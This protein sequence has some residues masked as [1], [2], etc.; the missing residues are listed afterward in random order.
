MFKQISEYFEPFFSKFQCDFWNG[1]SLQQCFLSMLE[2]WKLAVDNQK[3]FWALLWDLSKAFDCLSH[4]LFIAKL[5]AYGFN[6][7]SL[8]LVK[9]YLISR[10]Q[11]TRINSTYSSWEENLFRVCQGSILGPLLFNIFFC[12]LFSIVEDIDFACYADN[13]TPYTIGNDMEDVTFKFQNNNNNNNN[14]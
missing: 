14:K 9:D 3:R 10:K 6:I 11:R 4:D 12:G 13:N 5:N 2:K 8:R 7:D 1:F